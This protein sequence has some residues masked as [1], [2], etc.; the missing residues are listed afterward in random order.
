MEVRTQL[1]ARAAERLAVA[2][3]RQLALV[4]LSAQR[5]T[6]LQ[7]LAPLSF[8]CKYFLWVSHQLTAAAAPSRWRRA[9][10]GGLM[11]PSGIFIREATH[12]FV[13]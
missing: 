8:L 11:P 1:R 12:K 13:G 4:H 2:L 9:R 6:Y 5:L 10:R 7:L 3:P